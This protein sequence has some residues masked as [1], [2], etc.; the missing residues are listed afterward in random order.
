MNLR[1]CLAFETCMILTLFARSVIDFEEMA[2]G[3]NKR[4]IIQSSVFN[5]LCKVRLMLFD[6]I[7]EA[8]VRVHST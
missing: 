4:R 8:N 1:D 7:V 3:L 6:D 5:E 2:A